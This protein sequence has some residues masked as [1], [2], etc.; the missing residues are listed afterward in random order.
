M[1]A[2]LRLMR[3]DVRDIE[4]VAGLAQSND[5]DGLERFVVGALNDHISIGAIFLELLQGAGQ[6]LRDRYE[7]GDSS[8]SELALSIG[9][10][11]LVA[12]RWAPELP[13][14]SSLDARS[15]ILL[16]P[17]ATHLSLSPTLY[18]IYCDCSGWSVEPRVGE[19]PEVGSDAVY[20][21]LV[22][23]AEQL[24]QAFSLYD[25]LRGG[26]ACLALDPCL[27]A[28]VEEDPRPRLEDAG[29]VPAFLNRIEAAQRA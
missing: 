8:K 29:Q 13:R 18:E 24:A 25:R 10:L 15:V 3:F 28:L 9:A 14:R 20:F 6:I 2:T 17:E 7:N 4:A 5:G 21:V 11:R 16:R 12:L 23:A 19:P 26:H 1:T 27:A 22:E